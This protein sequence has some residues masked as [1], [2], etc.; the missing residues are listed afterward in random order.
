MPRTPFRSL[1]V[2]L[3]P[4]VLALLAVLPTTAASA[5]PAA[6]SPL[7]Q[8]VRLTDEGFVPPTLRVREGEE[9]TWVNASA[10]TQTLLGEE[11]SWDSGP[12]QPGE[13]FSLVLRLR[14]TFRYAT[15]DGVAEGQLVVAAPAAA[16][17]AAPERPTSVEPART[18]A[19]TGS[20]DGA[21]LAWSCALLVVGALAVHGAGRGQP[22]RRRAARR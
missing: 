5:A 7:V 19:D 12:L 4:A 13:R 18:L 10:T 11:G 14:G 17:P 9:V 21:L 2:L 20:P 6:T 1:R 22:R 8:E 3:L 15:S 16:E